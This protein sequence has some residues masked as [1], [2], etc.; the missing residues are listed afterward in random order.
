MGLKEKLFL[1]YLRTKLKL[2]SFLSKKKAAAYA[3]T[4]FTT[5]QY[6]NKKDL[7]PLFLSAE[8][9]DLDFQ[10]YKLRGYAWNTSSQKKLL[11]LHGFESSVIN[12]VQYVQPLLDN[13]FAVYAFDAPAHGR[14][15]GKTVN[16]VIYKEFIKTLHQKYGPFQNFITHSFGGLAL[17]L[18][19]EEMPHDENYKVV[20]IA[21][22]TETTRAVEQ[23]FTLFRLEDSL[24]PAFE[25]YIE[26]ISG[27][28]SAWFSVNRASENIKANVLWIHDSEDDMTP[29]ADVEPVMKKKFANFEFYITRGLGHRRIY[30]DKKVIEKIINFMTEGKVFSLVNNN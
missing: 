3:F 30:R 22:A 2:L 6:R 21:P 25:D 14:S 8:T 27:H 17:S 4:L 16:A 5:P 19:L 13:G 11:V 20:F 26:K 1:F 29:M 15:S 10:T 18:A 9:I 12:F 24:Y 28:R 23:L 7:P